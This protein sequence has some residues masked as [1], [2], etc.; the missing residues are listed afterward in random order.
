MVPALMDALKDRDD[1]CRRVRR[2]VSGTRWSAGQR[3][4]TRP[5]RGPEGSQWRRASLGCRGPGQDHPQAKGVVAALTEAVAD[6]D[7]R[8]RQNAASSL[9]RIGPPAKTAI[10]LL[11]DALKDEDQA[12][13]TRAA[14]RQAD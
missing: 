10:P 3:G 4:R 2:L 5:Y 9:G 6:H 8:V 12:V 13:R 7:E 11:I 1:A 14:R